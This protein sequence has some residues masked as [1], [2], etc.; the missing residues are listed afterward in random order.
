MTRAPAEDTKARRA[1]LSVLFAVLGLS[2]PRMQAQHVRTVRRAGSR[3]GT[4]RRRA[5]SA[6][7]AGARAPRGRVVVTNANAASSQAQRAR[8]PA[9]SALQGR[10]S[11]AMSQRHV[12]CVK[13]V[14]IRRPQEAT[15]ARTA[16]LGAS[17]TVR[18]VA[19]VASVRARKGQPTRA[20]RGPLTAASACMATTWT[21]MVNARSAQMALFVIAQAPPWTSW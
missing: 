21:P 3:H 20:A 16:A 18:E 12:T 1:K 17:K 6:R 2:R 5:T 7:W 13:G 11:Q 15:N 10:C 4:A 9:V 14:D 19:L 8:Q